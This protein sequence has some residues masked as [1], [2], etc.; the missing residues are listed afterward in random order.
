MSNAS[1]SPPAVIRL[2][3]GPYTE[4]AAREKLWNGTVQAARIGISQPTLNR[5][6]RGEIAPGEKFIAALLAATG[7]P[8]EEMFEVVS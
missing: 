7:A 6:R 8:F 5:I 3:V 4:W 1:P 2:R